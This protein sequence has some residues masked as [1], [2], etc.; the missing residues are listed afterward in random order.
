MAKTGQGNPAYATIAD[1][2]GCCFNTVCAA[3]KALEGAGIL[4]WV[5]RIHR[6][7]V[8]ERDLFGQ[9]VTSWRVVGT[10]NAYTLPRSETGSTLWRRF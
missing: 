6:I 7:R 10:S 3:I 9:L 1:K 5:N 8:R 4:S 2:A